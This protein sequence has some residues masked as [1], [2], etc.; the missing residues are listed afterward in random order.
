MFN[1]LEFV[2]DIFTAVF[3]AEALVK[4]IATGPRLYFNDSWNIFDFIII[5]GSSAGIFISAYSSVKIKG[6]TSVF[7]A[8]RIMRIMRLLKRGGNSMHLIFNTFVLTLH[9][10]VN[11]GGLLIVFIYMYSILGMMVF[12]QMKRNGIMNDYINFENFNNAFI[13]LFTVATGDSWH[14]TA[15][16][17]A[18]TN[19]PINDCIENATYADYVAHSGKTMSC[20]SKLE[21]YLFFVT[22][23]FVVNL[24]FLKLFIAIIL[25][26]YNNTQVQDKRLF[27]IDMNDKFRETWA[28]FDPEAT[29]FI[30]MY[31]LRDFLFALGE[32]LGFDMR[33]TGKRLMQDQFIA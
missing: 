9:S 11:I 28:E 20:G 16:A 31:K 4:I 14:Y 17:F 30:P 13:T 19:S 12:G 25:Q 6:A 1:F 27:N 24:V 10:L 33:Y 29:T 15:E 5:L 22:Y 18:M 8:F 23:M 32:P 21:S 3:I 26:G 2:N 7:R